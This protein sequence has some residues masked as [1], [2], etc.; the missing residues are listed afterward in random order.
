MV[1]VPTNIAERCR[2]ETDKELKYFN[3]YILE[4]LIDRIIVLRKQLHQLI[5]KI[6]QTSQQLKANNQQL[7]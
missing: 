6:N 7:K 4:Y 2:I 5:N 1:S 3:D